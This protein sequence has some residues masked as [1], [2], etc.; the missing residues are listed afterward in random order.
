M[1]KTLLTL[2]LLASLVPLTGCFKKCSGDEAKE[3][4][5]NKD[6]SENISDKE[7]QAEA[8]GFNEGLADDVAFEDLDLESFNGNSPRGRYI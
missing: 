5:E 3:K 6:K 2:A 7:E 1:K 4:V 8:L